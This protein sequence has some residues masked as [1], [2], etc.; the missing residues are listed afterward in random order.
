MIL[1]LKECVKVDDQREVFK[2]VV[3]ILMAFWRAFLYLLHLCEFKHT[4]ALDKLVLLG[5]IWPL[6]VVLLIFM[7]KLLFLAKVQLL[8]WLLKPVLYFI[9]STIKNIHSLMPASLS[10][11]NEHYSQK[12]TWYWLLSHLLAT[13]RLPYFYS[14]I[15]QHFSTKPPVQ[16]SWT[17]SD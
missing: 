10:Q 17:Q 2:E 6:P 14:T 16:D 3:V 9:V 8:V 1:Y 5:L 4:L 15:L 12:M 11:F 13:N 7:V